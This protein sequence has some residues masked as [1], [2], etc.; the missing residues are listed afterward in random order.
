MNE[1]IK[2]ENISSPENKSEAQLR[3]ELHEAMN[4]VEKI[5]TKVDQVFESTQDIGKAEDIVLSE[6]GLSLDEAFK[7]Q[8]KLSTQWLES[9]DR[10]Q[11]EYEESW[12]K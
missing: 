3:K 7:K 6:Y 9:M 12:E 4:E 5:M 1:Q 8:R 2:M 11:K 10:E